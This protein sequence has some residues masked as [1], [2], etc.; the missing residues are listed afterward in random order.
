MNIIE[1]IKN[2]FFKFNL[3]KNDVEPVAP[4]RR[5]R[6]NTELTMLHLTAKIHIQIINKS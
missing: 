6:I 1:N 2:S 5:S 4:I 3:L